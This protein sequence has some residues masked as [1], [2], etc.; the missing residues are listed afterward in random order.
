ML[1]RPAIVVGTVVL[2]ILTS[3]LTAAI[4]TSG[5]DGAADSTLDR[6]ET[7]ASEHATNGTIQVSASGEAAAPPDVALVRVAV[8]ATGDTAEQ[9]RSRVADNA[10]SMRSALRDSD[11]ADDQ[12][13]TTYFDIA[14]VRDRESN[15]TSADSYRA[16]HAFEIEVQVPADDLGERTG[17]IIDT[18]VQNGANRVEGVQFTLA[19]DTRRELRTQALERAVE[20]ARTDADVVAGAADRTVTGVHSIS[21]SSDGMFGPDARFDEAGGGGADTVIDPGPVRVSATVS[22]TYRIE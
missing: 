9:A 17:A 16:V 14:E 1:S 20:D 8:V 12:I 18:A 21:V 4:V 3:G 22:V 5:S 10:S 7:K 6:V 2:L 15:A 19:E 13:R 11:V